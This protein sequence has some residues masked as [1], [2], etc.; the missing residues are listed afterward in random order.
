MTTTR[1]SPWVMSNL[2]KHSGEFS[3]SF[4]LS[5]NP[6]VMEA[7]AVGHIPSA[8]YHFSHWGYIEGRLPRPLLFDETWYRQNNPD[9]D[10]A[11][12]CGYFSSGYDHYCQHGAAE[13]RAPCGPIKAPPVPR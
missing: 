5:V 7:I 10:D 11:I 1:V 13:R 3:E 6:D 12:K 2:L 8:Q 4:Y 9:V